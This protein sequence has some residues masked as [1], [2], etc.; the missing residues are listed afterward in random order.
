MN[1][2]LV[3]AGLVG[4]A[5]LIAHGRG[6][7]GLRGN[8]RRG[9]WRSRRGFLG[10]SRRGKRRRALLG[11][12]RRGFRGRCRIR[13]AEN[14]CR[15]AHA[16]KGL[17]VDHA[18]LALQAL[19]HLLP[20]SGGPETGVVAVLQ[21]VVVAAVR[22]DL[23]TL[24]ALDDLGSGGS[25]FAGRG[26]AGRRRRWWK[27]L[28][29]V[30]ELAVDLASLAL[31]TLLDDVPGMVGVALLERVVFATELIDSRTLTIVVFLGRGSIRWRNALAAVDKLAVDLASLA[32]LTLLDRLPVSDSIA[33]LESVLTEG[34]PTKTNLEALIIDELGVGVN[35]IT[36][37]IVRGS[38]LRRAQSSL[39]AVLDRT[40]LSV[41]STL[42]QVVFHV[43][44]AL[45]DD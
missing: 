2:V 22:V 39:G 10:S 27:T 34:A 43:A 29:A 16:F 8:S 41:I 37:A 9:V 15:H 17:L 3:A 14:I 5:W 19:L 33:G 25:G 38:L 32:L 35:G 21:H 30:E 26:H 18:D 31:L 6:R 42:L 23:R 45:G 11:R 7:R 28:A 13:I 40:P 24:V 36:A 20:V 12:S 1:H 4:F 44:A